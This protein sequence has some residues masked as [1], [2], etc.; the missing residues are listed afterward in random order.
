[1]LCAFIVAVAWSGLR[2]WPA[3]QD[4]RIQLR[5]IQSGVS[6]V[7]SLPS[8]ADVTALDS[9]V[10]LLLADLNTLHDT[11]IPWEGPLLFTS[12]I[13]PRVHALALQVAPLLDY[14][15]SVAEAGHLLATSMG[16]MLASTERTT[17]MATSPKLIADLDAAHAPF[18]EA[19]SLFDQAIQARRKLS[20][21]QLPGSLRAAF[22][23]LDPL[24]TQAPD[25]LT[26][27][28]TLP[29][30]LGARGPR[31]YLVVPQN[32]EDLRATGGFIRTVSI[33]HVDHGKVSLIDMSDA[34][35]I[36]SGHGR[37]PNVNPPLPMGVHGWGTWYFRDANWSADFPTSAQLLQIFY[38]LG[39]GRSVDGVIAFD[40]LFLP[41]LLGLTGPVALPEYHETL[42]AANAFE[43]IDYH[44]NVL[45]GGQ[46][47]GVAFAAAAYRA[48]FAHLQDL[49][50]SSLRSALDVFRGA[51]QA[52]HL[53]LYATDPSVE[54]AIQQVG[55]DGAINRAT[56]DYLYVVDT[57]MST[58]KVNQS[59]QAQTSY[60]ATIQA[61]RSILATLTLTYTNNAT[62][63]NL[64]RQNGVP[65]YSDFI[66]VFV[67]LGSERLS[68]SGLDETWPTYVVHFKT[69]FSGYF[70]LPSKTTR[71]ITLRY[72]IPANVAASSHYALLVQKQ[73]GTDSRPLDILV[74][75]V[76][77]VAL[78]PAPIHAVTNLAG[79][80]TLTAA[81]T[82]GSPPLAQPHPVPFEPYV[83]PGSQPEVWVTV[84]SATLPVSLLP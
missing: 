73:P 78:H 43:R 51:I 4:A 46:S 49:P 37:R 75:S 20:L 16:P 52:R 42:T 48:T 67:P 39:V 5:V 22:A 33:L 69:Q 76:P 36:D 41:Q 54:A 35:Q 17:S 83:V 70:K 44:I 55:A 84:P 59:I 8:S 74:D 6:T 60:K 82:G 64:P 29:D 19:S 3:A 27:L 34:Y 61:D 30:A 40:S 14:A 79:D 81:L 31:N 2:A 28:A 47:K 66:R 32:S 15:T 80:R 9:H 10:V 53:L 23:R 26:S 62:T 45:H 18:L 77:G 58:N 1:M 38:R 7:K 72:R 24:V 65:Q 56:S 21:A 50:G 13:I 68:S 71:R 57:N 11:W 63:Q 25:L 12:N